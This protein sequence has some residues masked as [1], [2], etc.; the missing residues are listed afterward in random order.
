[1]SGKAPGSPQTSFF[2]T[3]VVFWPWV[4][5]YKLQRFSATQVQEEG[6]LCHTWAR[7]IGTIPIHESRP[8]VVFVAF[9][10]VLKA[11]Q[12]VFGVLEPQIHPK[13]AFFKL[14]KNTTF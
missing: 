9:S 11:F 14:P 2:Q 1:M 5:F 12:V 7:E 10:L 4:A 8:I 13:M 3:S 6:A